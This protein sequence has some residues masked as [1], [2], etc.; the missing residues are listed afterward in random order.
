MLRAADDGVGDAAPL[1]PVEDRLLSAGL[2]FAVFASA[3]QTVVHL[4]NAAFLEKRSLNVNFEENAFA[5][6]STVAAFSVAFVATVCAAGLSR[7]R[8]RYIALALVTAFISLDDM[9]VIHE[10]VG[11]KA[12]E[13]LGLPQS[14]DSLLWPAIY[15]PLLALGFLVL[16]SLAREAP[17]RA[18]RFI[19]V[20]LALFAFALVA[21]AASAPW[22]GAEDEWPHVIEGAFEEAAELAAWILIATALTVVMLRELLRTAPAARARAGLPA[23]PPAARRRRA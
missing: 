5:W 11:T 21:E 6:A 16:L 10:E 7:G 3:A 19:H 12:T 1:E 9:V 2:A 14:F 22:T 18:R 4:L 15:F 13:T 8:G 23:G 17:A 20:G